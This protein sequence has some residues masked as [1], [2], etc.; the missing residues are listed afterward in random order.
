MKKFIL[1]YKT[2]T[3]L[4]IVAFFIVISYILTGDLPEL[5]LYGDAFYKLISDLSL[6][7]IASYIF[8]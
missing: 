2:T 1:S 6:A 5:F 4:L 3:L 8:S 7:Y